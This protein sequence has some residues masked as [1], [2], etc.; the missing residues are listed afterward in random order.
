MNVADEDEPD[1]S[2]DEDDMEEDDS[3][4]ESEEDEGCHHNSEHIS[5]N[6]SKERSLTVGTFCDQS[7][8]IRTAHT[9]IFFIRNRL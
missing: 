7:S 3:N 5:P 8:G 2:Y 9:L 6:I 1:S 4:A